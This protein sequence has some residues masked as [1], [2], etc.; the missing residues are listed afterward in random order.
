VLHDPAVAGVLL[1][2]GRRHGEALRVAAVDVD[3]RAFGCEPLGD[4]AAEPVGGSGDQ[5]DRLLYGHADRG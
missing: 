1:D 4:P 3:G 2:L 5:G